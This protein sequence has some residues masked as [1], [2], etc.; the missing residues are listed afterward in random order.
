MK[1]SKEVK[2]GILTTTSIIILFTGFYF[3]KGAN[4]FSDDR[5]Y[6]CYYDNVEGLMSSANIELKGL[7]VGRV[8]SMDFEEGKGVKVGLAIR[9]SISIPEGSVATIASNNLLGNKIIKLAL[10][11]SKTI[12]KKGELIKSGKDAGLIGNMAEEV[13]PLVKSLKGTVS[14]LDTTLTEINDL[15]NA[16]NRKNIGEAIKHINTTTQHIAKLSE[17][18]DKQS[19]DM[20]SIIKNTNA[21]TGSLAKSK[22]TVQQM[23]NNLNRVSKQL[24]N[25]PLEQTISEMEIAVKELKGVLHKINNNEGSLGMLVNDKRLHSD[26]STSLTSMDALLKDLKEHPSR[27]INVSVFGRK[28][29]DGK[30]KT[31]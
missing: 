28:N 16:E 19:G 24:A 15:L 23:L 3:L 12:L 14:S 1:I 10:G 6:Y 22:D 26:L 9:K 4:L 29:K 18:L 2:I 30:K 20:Q 8:A 27:Y 7:S 31:K 25:A 5:I 17:A 11:N 13:S 21:F